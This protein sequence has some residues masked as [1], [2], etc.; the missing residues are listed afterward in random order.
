MMSI[1]G[2]YFSTPWYYRRVDYPIGIGKIFKRIKD[3][4]GCGRKMLNKI[5]FQSM[6]YVLQT[7][8]Y[9]LC[10]PVVRKR[11][12]QASKSLSNCGKKPITFAVFECKFSKKIELVPHYESAVIDP[13]R[14]QFDDAPDAEITKLF[15]QPDTIE[16]SKTFESLFFF[17]YLVVEC[18][19]AEKLGANVM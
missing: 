11:F 1:E 14:I 3:E 4:N 17:K 7:Q 6:D 8:L 12:W 9:H 15:R 5:M 18:Y 10:F 2:I 16:F 19:N 13:S